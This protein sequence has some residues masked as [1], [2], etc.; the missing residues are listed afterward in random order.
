MRC[1]GC[2]TEIFIGRMLKDGTRL[3]TE[4]DADAIV[5]T[6]ARCAAAR[7]TPAEREQLVGLVEAGKRASPDRCHVGVSNTGGK[8]VLFRGAD[9]DFAALAFNARPLLARL[10]GEVDRG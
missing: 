1:P 2:G 3:F 5:H 6:P 10:A 8:A 7:L 4:E 9:A